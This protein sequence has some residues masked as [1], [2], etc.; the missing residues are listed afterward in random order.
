MYAL[1]G[2]GVSARTTYSLDANVLRDINDR[3]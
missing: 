2:N 1:F 3:D